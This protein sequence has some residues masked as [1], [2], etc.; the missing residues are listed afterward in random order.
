[1]AKAKTVKTEK[2]NQPAALVIE[3][4]KQAGII[5]PKVRKRNDIKGTGQGWRKGVAKYSADQVYQF[6]KEYFTSCEEKHRRPT[7][8]GLAGFMDITSETLLIWMHADKAG[9]KEIYN[10]DVSFI[11]KKAQ[12]CMTD[13][14]QQGTDSM[15]IF[16]LKQP[17]YGG[18]IDRIDNASG[19]S[20]NIAV[21]F[22]Q[23]D[24]KVVAEYGK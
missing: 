18:Y 23:S 10:P 4:Q 9:G 8:E 13:E 19:G 12:D 21:S 14:L 15:S 20:V 11:L 24:G 1:M 3:D 6:C 16:R 2:A 5:T 7:V 17:R 22:G